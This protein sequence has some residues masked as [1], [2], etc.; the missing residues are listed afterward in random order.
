MFWAVAVF[1]LFRTIDSVAAQDIG[2]HIRARFG[3]NRSRND[4]E[5]FAEEKHGKGKNHKPTENN[6]I[7]SITEDPTSI[8]FQF[9]CSFQSPQL[10]R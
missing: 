5:K 7:I 9:Y 8:I 3:T 2:R 6:I 1:E 4:R 10:S